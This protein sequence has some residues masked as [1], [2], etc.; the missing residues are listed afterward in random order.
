VRLEAGVDGARTREVPHY[1][2][3]I[4]FICD[5]LKWRIE[6]FDVYR[7]RIEYPLVHTNTFTDFKAAPVWG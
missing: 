4:S 1:I 2:D 6:D 5:K 3:M 7:I